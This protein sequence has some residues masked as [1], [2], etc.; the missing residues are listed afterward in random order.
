MP[1]HGKQKLANFVLVNWSWYVCT[2]EQ[3]LANMLA[4]NRTCNYSCQPFSVGKRIFDT[5]NYCSARVV[6]F[7]PIKCRTLF[8][9]FYLI[10][11]ELRKMA[12]ELS[13]SVS[14]SAMKNIEKPALIRNPSC[15]PLRHHARMRRRCYFSDLF[16]FVKVW[17]VKA[18]VSQLLFTV[19]RRP[20]KTIGVLVSRD[21]P[22]LC[23]ISK[24][25]KYEL[26]PIIHLPLRSADESN[27]VIYWLEEELQ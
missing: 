9:W 5:V 20:N 26:S 24:V 19:W 1:S 7:Q 18:R 4:T 6:H 23:W 27:H 8:T 3:Q 22:C 16:I 25:D 13:V 14:F 21:P 17:R 10:C 15:M 11:D 12:A 2:L